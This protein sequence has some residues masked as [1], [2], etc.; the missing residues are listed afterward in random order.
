MASYD[1]HSYEIDMAIDF[2]LYKYLQLRKKASAGNN[3][4]VNFI[5][6]SAVCPW[7]KALKH[8]FHQKSV[9][10]LLE[11]VTILMAFSFAC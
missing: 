1:T 11:R 9:S 5:S 10:H 3:G 2:Q 6:V 8:C 7:Q 4:H